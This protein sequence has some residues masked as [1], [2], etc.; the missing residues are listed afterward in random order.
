[1]I[2]V[3]G[4]TFNNQLGVEA[5]MECRGGGRGGEDEIDD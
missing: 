3:D 1:M 2:K 5:L 4:G